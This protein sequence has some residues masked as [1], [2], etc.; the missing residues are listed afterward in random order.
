MGFLWMVMITIQPF[1][2]D[3]DKMN[4]NLRS[5]IYPSSN[6]YISGTDG[7]FSIIYSYGV[8]LSSKLTP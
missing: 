5:L 7:I 1:N 3:Y 8:N 2:L 4:I 6:N